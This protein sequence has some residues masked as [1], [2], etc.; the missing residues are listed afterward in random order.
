[1]NDPSDLCVDPMRKKLNW[2]DSPTQQKK[3]INNLLWYV[4]Q[5]VLV[6]CKFICFSD[7]ISIRILEEFC[8]YLQNTYQRSWKTSENYFGNWCFS[9]SPVGILEM[10]SEFFKNSIWKFN[11]NSV[12]KNSGIKFLFYNVCSDNKLKQI[13]ILSYQESGLPLYFTL[14]LSTLRG[15]IFDYVDQNLSIIKHLPTPGWNCI[16]EKIP[17]LLHI[18]KN[19]HKYCIT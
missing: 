7:R 14:F 17:T 2:S 5:Y 8:Y 19:L 3:P 15:S 16:G 1:M 11:Q 10:I 13:H 12:G 9:T 4:I 6:H 18:R